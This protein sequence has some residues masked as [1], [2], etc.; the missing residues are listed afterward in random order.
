MNANLT[1]IRY[2]PP[3]ST[4]T[5]VRIRVRRR[6]GSRVLRHFRVVPLIGILLAVNSTP[7]FADA[8][9][10]AL[11][12]DGEWVQFHV[13]LNVSGRESMPVWT[14]KSVGKKVVAGA[15]H[16]WIELQSKE[17]E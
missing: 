5:V 9:I 12:D 3:G 16:R 15:A 10:Q 1:R 6:C 14:V 17:G 2:V 8:L 11:P 4:S 13:I 7:I